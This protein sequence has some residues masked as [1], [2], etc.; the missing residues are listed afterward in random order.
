MK[1]I[2][3]T[4]NQGSGKTFITNESSKLGVPTL[5]MDVVAKQVQSDYKDPSEEYDN[6]MKRQISDED[7]RKMADYIITNDFTDNVIDSVYRINK[8][9]CSHI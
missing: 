8:I 2:G 7:K 9:L 3:I 4:G 1:K 6:R 5:L